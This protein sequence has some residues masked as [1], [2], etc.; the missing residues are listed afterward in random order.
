[1]LS[2]LW[3]LCLPVVPLFRLDSWSLL[4][5]LSELTQGCKPGHVKQVPISQRGAIG[6]FVASGSG[7][8]LLQSNQR[9]RRL[10][11]HHCHSWMLSMRW[12]L[13]L[14]EVQVIQL[15]SQSLLLLL[16][17]K[18]STYKPSLVT[19]VEIHQGGAIHLF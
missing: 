13:Y 16:S 3:E 5:L 18:V 14:P 11:C 10:L 9:L 19:Q 17:E 12:E 15:A 8:S 7:A 4:L 2:L 6:L 1:M